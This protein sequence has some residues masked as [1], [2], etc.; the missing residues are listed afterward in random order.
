MSNEYIRK[1]EG[2]NYTYL[3]DTV[4]MWH[5]SIHPNLHQHHQSSTYIL[6]Y[7]RILIRGQEKQVLKW[8]K[9]HT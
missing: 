2:N 8:F 1:A 3:N 9:Q 5:Q 6:P 7:F 4:D